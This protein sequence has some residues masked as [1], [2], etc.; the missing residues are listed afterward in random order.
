MR[1]LSPLL[2]SEGKGM[3]RVKFGDREDRIAV[4]P[5]GV[6]LQRFRSGK[7]IPSGE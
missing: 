6:T 2:I 3:Y 1:Q 7:L 4:L 5:D